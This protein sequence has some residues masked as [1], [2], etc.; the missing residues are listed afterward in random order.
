MKNTTLAIMLGFMLTLG[1]CA[2]RVVH[3]YHEITMVQT[4]PM[5]RVTEVYELGEEDLP[6]IERPADPEFLTPDLAGLDSP[7]E[8]VEG[9]VWISESHVDSGPSQDEIYE[10]IVYEEPLLDPV[11]DGFWYEDH[12]DRWYAESGLRGGWWY[13]YH[14]SHWPRRGHPHDPVP[15]SGRRPGPVDV[16]VERNHERGDRVA[17]R[18]TAER[19]RWIG[20]R[21]RVVRDAAARRD[22]SG[23]GDSGDRPSARESNPTSV[24]SVASYYDR[25]PP[26]ARRSERSADRSRGNSARSSPSV[27]P[28][29]PTAATADRR[30][31]RSSR[32]AAS[33][34]TPTSTSSQDRSRS[35]QR[36]SGASRTSS[37]SRSPEKVRVAS[38]SR[39]SGRSQNAGGSSSSRSRSPSKVRTSNSN[40]SRPTSKVRTPRRSNSSGNS[41]RARKSTSSRKS[42]GSSDSSAKSS[43]KSSAKSSA[44]SSSKSSG[45]AK[46]TKKKKKK[47]N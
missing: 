20:Q 16:D 37:R 10:T 11:D 46:K 25:K 26:T 19:R 30:S 24:G 2:S 3:R 32:I 17:A 23:N 45:K 18:R 40:G 39:T 15:Y 27:R 13:F 47:R 9:G 34:P 31:N 8:I 43:S 21:E 12:E 28:S 5:P 38:A 14:E 44:K 42:R 7:T 36:S 22:S 4:E 6:P 29:T 1:G 35:R 41:H 33:R